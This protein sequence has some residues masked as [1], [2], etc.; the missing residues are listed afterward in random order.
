MRI[1]HSGFHALVTEQVLNLSDIDAAHQQ[2]RCKAVAQRI[3]AADWG[4]TCLL[5]LKKYT[6]RLEAWQEDRG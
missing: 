1:D 5:T 4:Q 3:S 6:G 2:M